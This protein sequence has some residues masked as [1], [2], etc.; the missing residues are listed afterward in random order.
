MTDRRFTL[1]A[2]VLVYAMDRGASEKHERAIDLIARAAESDCILTLQALAEFFFV[3]TRKGMVS[4]REAATAVQ[5]WIEIFPTAA[6]D[7]EALQ[8]ALNPDSTDGRLGFWDAMLLG[9]AH[10]AGCRVALS[11]DMRDG[12]KFHGIAVIDPFRGMSLPSA[13]EALLEPDA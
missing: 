3:T 12:T 5:D 1:D 7:T 4:K 10:L 11:E 6:A 2:N 13:V 9:T 8:L